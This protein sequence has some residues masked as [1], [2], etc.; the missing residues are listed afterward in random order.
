MKGRLRQQNSTGC[1]AI[2]SCKQYTG[3]REKEFTAG[4][5]LQGKRVYSS[6]QVEGKKSLQQN[7]G[8]KRKDF[9]AWYWLNWTVD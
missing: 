8:W 6:I 3:W 1:R 2:K 5:R 9:T 4:Y 7:T